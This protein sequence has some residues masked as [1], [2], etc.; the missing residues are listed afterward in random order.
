MPYFVD[1]NYFVDCMDSRVFLRKDTCRFYRVVMQNQASFGITRDNSMN[2]F[3]RA[4]DN[5]LRGYNADCFRWQLSIVCGLWFAGKWIICYWQTL[6]HWRV[7]QFFTNLSQLEIIHDIVESTFLVLCSRVQCAGFWKFTFREVV[8]Q[9]ETF[10][11]L[12]QRPVQGLCLTTPLTDYSYTT[13]SWNL[14]VNYL[15]N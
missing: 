11:L 15:V 9:F 14:M 12:P 2:K 8:S 4:V 10:A 6:Y 13:L 1:S 5:S 7:R 3:L